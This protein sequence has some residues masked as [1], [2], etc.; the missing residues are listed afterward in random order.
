MYLVG[1]YKVLS[2]SLNRCGAYQENSEYASE[3]VHILQRISE[4]SERHIY[5]MDSVHFHMVN[6]KIL[7]IL[8]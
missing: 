5:C 7:H 8:F 4:M 3:T 1:P 6:P 2:S